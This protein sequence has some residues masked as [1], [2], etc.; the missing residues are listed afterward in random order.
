MLGNQTT[1]KSI[2]KN[3]A[4]YK[5]PLLVGQFYTHFNRN[6]LLSL[7]SVEKLKKLERERPKDKDYSDT[8]LG[9]QTE[10]IMASNGT[11]ANMRYLSVFSKD[12]RKEALPAISTFILV[13]VYLTNKNPES[14]DKE[15]LKKIST[16]TDVKTPDRNKK[17]AIF[18]RVLSIAQ[19]L[20]QW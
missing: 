7:L 6:P 10:T 9:K 16:N 8:R 20:I 3:H 4:K 5:E 19:I 11:K 17:T 2:S 12:S 1:V 15:L 13:A 18:Q 14:M